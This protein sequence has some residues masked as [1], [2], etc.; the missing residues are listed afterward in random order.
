MSDNPFRNLPSVHDVL[1]CPSLQA[2][3]DHAHDQIVGAVR[4]ELAELRQ[5]LARGE[6][7]DGQTDPD[8]LARR[9]LDRLQQSV[10]PKL[11]AVINATGI[12][13]HTNLGRAPMAAAAAQ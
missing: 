4:E 9:A 1:Q 13:L 12:V 6:A 10:R 7:P 11:R 5:R 8:A 2:V 3:S